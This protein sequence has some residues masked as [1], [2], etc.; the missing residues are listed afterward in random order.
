MALLRGVR[1][2]HRGLI[3]LVALAILGGCLRDP[4][5]PTDPE[6]AAEL[7]LPE[8][9]PIH[10][11]HLGGDRILPSRVEVDP[12]ARVHFVVEDHRVYALRFLLEEMESEAA[13]F[14]RE[15]EQTGSPPLA[16]QGA[17]HLVAFDDAPAGLYPFLLEGYGEPARGQI[18]VRE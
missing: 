18:R 5:P 12:G 2:S 7:G 11:V 15:S 9:T 6:L 17:W 3:V 13:A 10:R 16:R 14:L 4:P 1:D 8:R